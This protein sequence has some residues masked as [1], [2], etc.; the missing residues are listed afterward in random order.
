MAVSGTR[1]LERERG[2]H[3]WTERRLRLQHNPSAQF[4]FTCRR[5]QNLVE[6]STFT[7]LVQPCQDQAEPKATKVGVQYTAAKSKEHSRPPNTQ[8]RTS[9]VI[10]LPSRIRR[11][12]R[13]RSVCEAA[14]PS[15]DA[16]GHAEE[17][18]SRDL[19]YV[20]S[21]E[22]VTEGSVVGAKSGNVI[23]RGWLHVGYIYVGGVSR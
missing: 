19:Q 12:Y 7:A 3:Q 8:P 15:Y 22:G 18:G 2:D 6:A 23:S 13:S 21:A 16:E 9:L 11:D 10:L 4:D 14:Q 5:Q 1:Y 20:W 17:S